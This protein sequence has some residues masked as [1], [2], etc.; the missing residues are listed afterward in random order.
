MS[1]IYEDYLDITNRADDNSSNLNAVHLLDDDEFPL[2]FHS[3]PSIHNI[4]NNTNK[5]N[6]N[7]NNHTCATTSNMPSPKTHIRKIS[8]HAEDQEDDSAAAQQINNHGEEELCGG[9]E[10][11]ASNTSSSSISNSSS[12]SGS[13][14]HHV[15]HVSYV[16]SSPN[17]ANNNN[18]QQQQHM[19]SRSGMVYS[20][21]STPK[22]LSSSL[23]SSNGQQQR[24][25]NQSKASASIPSF[26]L[27]HAPTQSFEEDDRDN[28]GQYYDHA[29]NLAPA[30]TD[31]TTRTIRMYSTLDG[32]PVYEP[33]LDIRTSNIEQAELTDLDVLCGRGGGT[34]SWIGNRRYRAVVQSYQ[35]TYLKAKRKEKPMLARE[36]VCVIRSQGGRFLKKSGNSNSTAYEDIGDHK[37]EAKTAQALR[38]GLDVRATNAAA[39][40]LLFPKSS[41]SSGG[42]KLL[43]PRRSGAA[44]RRQGKNI[45]YSSIHPAVAGPVCF[46]PHVGPSLPMLSPTST[47]AA[48]APVHCAPRRMGNADNA[49]DNAP[50]TPVK[51]TRFEDDCENVVSAGDGGD[52]SAFV[53]PLSPATKRMRAEQQQQQQEEQQYGGA[54]DECEYD[55]RDDYPQHQYHHPQ[56]NYYHHPPQHSQ[57]QQYHHQGGYYYGAHQQQQPAQQQPR[58][59]PGQ[60][61]YW[62]PRSWD[63]E[64]GHDDDEE[65]DIQAV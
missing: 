33:P 23:S 25:Y 39:S 61:E 24:K 57:Q 5:S 60:F 7:N 53:P 34:N 59:T 47:S 19:R 35:P 32:S 29:A 50:A 41:S 11:D 65:D 56:Q 2:Y 52:G 49:A 26:A 9:S 40:N 58:F 12:G 44:S 20:P 46:V 64:E 27:P 18:N 16:H 28:K 30:V 36:I 62:S 43:S 48:T 55:Y 13:S 21:I 8:H 3:N 1:G 22:S 37:A 38:E 63:Q 6:I 14:S 45:I 42:K 54:E 10:A 31:G 17:S 51:R 15:K 4:I